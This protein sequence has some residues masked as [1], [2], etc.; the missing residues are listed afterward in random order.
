MAAH[1]AESWTLNTGVD[2]WLAAFERKVLSRLSGETKV[3]ENWRKQCNKELIQLF[4]DLDILSLVRISWLDW[5][6]HVNRGD[7]KIK[8]SQ[9][10]NN[11]PQGSQLRGRHK[12]NRC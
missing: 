1:R 6:G 4:G 7:S 10:F 9:M 12:K 3:D 11:N 5:I 8:V 2:K